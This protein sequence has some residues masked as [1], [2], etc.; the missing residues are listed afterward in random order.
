MLNVPIRLTLMT[1]SKSASGCGPS[2]PTTRFATPMPA[3]LISTRAGPWALAACTTAAS[4]DAA[5]VTSQA[6]AVPLISAATLSASLTLRSHTATFAP[7]AAS[8]RAVAAPNPDAPPVTIAAI[9]FNCMISSL[10]TVFLVQRYH[11]GRRHRR[12][13]F[14]DQGFALLQHCALVDRAFVSDFAAVDRQR[15]IQQDSAGDPRRR[16]GRGRK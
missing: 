6:M 11:V 8:R 9:S 14:L 12:I 1:L 2:R 7:C 13:Q 15:R 16:A 4:A 3:Q 10:E 5:S